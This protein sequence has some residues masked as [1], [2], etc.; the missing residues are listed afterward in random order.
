MS[1]EKQ[2]QKKNY[3]AI[4]QMILWLNQ[5]NTGSAENLA[6]VFEENSNDKY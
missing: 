1:V 3:N 5:K 6:S 4:R 2:K